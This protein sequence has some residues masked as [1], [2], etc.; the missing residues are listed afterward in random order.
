VDKGSAMSGF[1]VRG[2]SSED[3]CTLFSAIA[4]SSPCHLPKKYLA[5]LADW[6]DRCPDG[7]HRQMYRSVSNKSGE[8][9]ALMGM[10]Q[11]L[12]AKGVSSSRTNFS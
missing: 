9:L 5:F 3:I 6:S 4:C 8:A 10:G 7:N 12:R 2:R 1:A 11:A